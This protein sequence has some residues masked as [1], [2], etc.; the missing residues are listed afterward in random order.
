MTESKSSK[1]KIDLSQYKYRVSYTCNNPTFGD[2]FLM[3][4]NDIGAIKII[5]TELNPK[6][7]RAFAGRSIFYAIKHKDD[8]AKLK[9]IAQD[10]GGIVQV[11]SNITEINWD[12]YL[13]VT[14]DDYSTGSHLVKSD[15]KR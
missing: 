14:V 9:S 5:S 8:Y 6:T 11:A 2:D 10:L 13:S 3:K 1:F 15:R 4:A 7:G 12:N